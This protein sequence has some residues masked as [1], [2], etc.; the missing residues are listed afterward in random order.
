MRVAVVGGGAW[1]TALA[2]HA[3]RLDHDVVLW[4]IEPEVASDVTELHEN[5]AYLPGVS[6]PRTLRA[7]TDMGEAIGDARLVIL[8]PP[9]EHLRSV[10]TRVAVFRSTVPSSRS[11]CRTPASR[12]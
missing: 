11:S 2:S 1:G 8:V 9:S 6:L 3:A 4:A 10:A 5:R 12:V 7:T